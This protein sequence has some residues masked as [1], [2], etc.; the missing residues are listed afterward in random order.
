MG[1]P[2]FT[3]R[4]A[5]ARDVDSFRVLFDSASSGKNE[6][7]WLTANCRKIQYGATIR[8]WGSCPLTMVALTG[9]L[10]VEGVGSRNRYARG[11]ADDIALHLARSPARWLRRSCDMYYLV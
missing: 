9:G 7:F 1:L 11:G 5:I 2:W 8:D 4:A 3:S 10:R 6:D